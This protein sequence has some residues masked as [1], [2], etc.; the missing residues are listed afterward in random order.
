MNTVLTQDA[1]LTLRLFDWVVIDDTRDNGEIVIADDGGH[2]LTTIQQ[3]NAAALNHDDRQK[4]RTAD[5]LDVWSFHDDWC[6]RWTGRQ[7]F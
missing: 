7:N 6:D 1:R 2:W 3:L 4:V 5:L